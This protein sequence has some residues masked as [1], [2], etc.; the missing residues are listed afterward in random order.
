MNKNVVLRCALTAGAL[1]GVVA[2]SACTPTSSGA[3][4]PSGSNPAT[5]TSA[6]APASQPV[7]TSAAA[8][9]KAAGDT[10]A[11]PAHIYYPTC[12]GAGHGGKSAIEPAEVVFSCDSTLSL[13]DAHWT[14]WNGSYAEATGTLSENDCTPSCANGTDH[15]NKVQVRFDKPVKLSCGEFWSDVVFTYVGKPV[16]VANAKSPWTFN[17]GQPSSY[18]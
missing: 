17:P 16:G 2:I 7:A 18:C 12:P 1:A 3:P 4:A 9:A 14:T 5:G 11:T 6:Q 15:K 13:E 8:P 10:A